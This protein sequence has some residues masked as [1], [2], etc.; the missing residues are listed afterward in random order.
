MGVSAIVFV[1][2]LINSPGTGTEKAHGS[3]SAHR[4]LL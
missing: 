2:A 3:T 1:S 4:L